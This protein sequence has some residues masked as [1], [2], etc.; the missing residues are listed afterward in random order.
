MTTRP[1][2][3]H[4]PR[5][6]LAAHLVAAAISVIFMAR[7]AAAADDAAGAAIYRQRCASC[8]GSAG[9]GTPDE[10][11]KPLVG[12]RSVGQLVTLIAKT[13]PADDPGTC[14][15][16][17]ARRVAAYIHDT[18]YSAAARARNKPARVELS[19]LTV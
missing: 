7:P 5:P 18:F 19:R 8:H 17:D 9:E 12:N 11:P 1:S 3:P 6:T 4:A 13:M 14:L 16:E 10:Y 15:G 2:T